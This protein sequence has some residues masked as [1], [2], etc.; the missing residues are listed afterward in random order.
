MGMPMVVLRGEIYTARL[1]PTEGSELQK[2]RPC[3]IV[4]NDLDNRYSPE[5]LV[6]PLTEH[7]QGRLYTSEVLPE[8]PEAG[9]KKPSRVVCTQIRVLDKRRLCGPDG[10]IL[11]RWGSVSP[12]TLEAV[13][14]GLA[15]ALNLTPG[16]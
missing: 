10:E 14:Q 3:L 4:S 12:Q 11:R 15:I 13:N 1:D 9:L 7:K 5:V 8:P 16:G 6:V 2:P